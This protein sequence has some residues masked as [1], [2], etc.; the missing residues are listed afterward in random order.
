MLS[1]DGRTVTF[2]PKASLR[3]GETYT[4]D[5]SD[6]TDVAQSKVLGATITLKTFEPRQLCLNDGNCPATDS[7]AYQF[8]M[9]DGGDDRVA[10]PGYT[11]ELEP[12]ADLDFLR[13]PDAQ[14]RLRTNLFLTLGGYG[15]I[16]YRLS[17]VD[18]T[19]PRRPNEIAHEFGGRGKRRMT[20][21]PGSRTSASRREYVPGIAEPA[22]QH[23][24]GGRIRVHV[25]NLLFTGDIAVTSSFT[26][27]TSFITF[28][29]V[30]DPRRMPVHARRQDAD[31]EPGLRH[32]L[33][34]Q[35]HDSRQRLRARDR[36]DQ[37]RRRHLAVHGGRGGRRDGDRPRREHSGRNP[38]ARLKDTLY[39]GDVVDIRAFHDR[40]LIARRDGAALR[41]ARRQPDADRLDRSAAAAGCGSSSP[42][43]SSSTRTRT[44]R[45]RRTRCKDL[46]FLA[47]D[48]CS[49]G[50]GAA[51][52]GATAGHR[53]ARET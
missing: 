53:P 3:L 32:R 46:A 39:S 10:T 17:T 21:I 11:K 41:G 26:P 12:I 37:A 33:Q 9:V 19:D 23:R 51:V 38:A 52:A 44:A 24:P 36:G 27:E 28:Y 48:A 35:S 47:T 1:P 45:S 40:L 31:G 50:S 30:T 25:P 20:L 6:V 18:V 43:R 13:T 22:L 14:G 29:N 49:C 15:T 16:D 4:L 5:F 42:K 7:G 2:V 34:P 8:T